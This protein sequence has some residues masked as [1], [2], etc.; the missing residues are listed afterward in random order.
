MPDPNEPRRC[1]TYARMSPPCIERL[2]VIFDVAKYQE[3]QGTIDA[4]EATLLTARRL[5]PNTIRR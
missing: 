4:A 2:L 1:L 5:L 3:S